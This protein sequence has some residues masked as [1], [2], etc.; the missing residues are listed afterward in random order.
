[1]GGV[2]EKSLV[3]VYHPEETLKSRF[4]Q[5]RRE[6]LLEGI[7]GVPEAEGKPQAL[8]HPVGGEDCSLGNIL[9]G[10]WDLEIQPV[11]NCDNVQL[12]V[13]STGPPDSALLLN[14]VMRRRPW[15]GGSLDYPCFPHGGDLVLGCSKFLR[16]QPPRF[17]KNRRTR[18]G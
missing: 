4:I 5:R 12:S 8:K 3:E 6:I 2:L 1:M 15:R 17:G 7:A 14:H 11:R 9:G 16:V 13:V 10:H 18:V